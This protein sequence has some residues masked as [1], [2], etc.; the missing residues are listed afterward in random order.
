METGRGNFDV[1][2]ALSIILLLLAYLINLV[3]T[4]V[5]QRERPSMTLRAVA[6]FEVRNL[7]VIR[8]GSLILNVPS[9]AVSEGKSWSS[10]ARTGQAKAPSSNSLRGPGET[11][12]GR[13]PFQRAED[14]RGYSPCFSIEENLPW[15]CR[16]LFSS[17]RRCITMS[18]AA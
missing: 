5:Q 6:V 11:F 10:S 15:F 14:R 8:G 9:L 2:I 12:P 4:Q 7:Q 3:L 16:S 17:T 1:A 18:R 13:D